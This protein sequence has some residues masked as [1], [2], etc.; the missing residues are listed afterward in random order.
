[1]INDCIP[2]SCMDVASNSL[3][4]IDMKNY[5]R[6]ILFYVLSFIII[7]KIVHD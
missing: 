2:K 7:T 4:I 5:I 3:Q 6:L 1:M